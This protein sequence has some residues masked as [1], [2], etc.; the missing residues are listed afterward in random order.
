MGL[1]VTRDC[2][3]VFPDAIA[4]DQEQKSASTQIGSNSVREL[5]FV[6]LWMDGT[7]KVEQSVRALPGTATHLTL[8][9]CKG[10][11]TENLRVLQ[12]LAYHLPP[13][14]RVPPELAFDQHG[15]PGR[16]DK[17]VVHPPP[18]KLHFPAH[19]Y[20]ADE[21]RIN[22]RNRQGSRMGVDQSLD[23]I[24]QHCFARAML[25]DELKSRRTPLL[26]NENG[27]A[28]L[29]VQWRVSHV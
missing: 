14:L 21:Q 19:R 15:Q 6:H 8:Q 9:V 27:R 28:V 10:P 18:A 1:Q 4:E 13:S 16:G 3:N 12:D 7:D 20:R 25:R 17:E 24:L 11:A 2:F 29:S 23:L 22:F 5:D 26:V